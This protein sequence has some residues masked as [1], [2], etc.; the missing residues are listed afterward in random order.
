MKFI[1]NLNIEGK[2]LNVLFFFASIFIFSQNYPIK[3]GVKVG[4]NYSVVDA[5]DNEGNLSGYISP[6]IDEIYGGLAIEKQFSPKSFIQ[7]GL[8]VSYTESVTVLELPI[9]YKYNF[10][11]RFSSL[12]GVK[13]DYLPDEQ[14][15]QF[16]Y[17]RNR[18]GF[19]LNLGLDYKISK[20]LSTEAY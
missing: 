11:K 10:H 19:S 7:T 5:I 8:L 9:F 18:F 14:Y 17:F 4:W 1:N 3:Y 13:I 6:I 15:N 20:K 16:Y 2:T 12:L